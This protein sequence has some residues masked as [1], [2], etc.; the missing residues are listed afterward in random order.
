[1][2]NRKHTYKNRIPKKWGKGKRNRTNELLKRNKK[3]TQA[4]DKL[5]QKGFLK[6]LTKKKRPNI[7]PNRSTTW[8]L[9]TIVFLSSLL[10]IIIIIPTLIVAPFA[11][12]H[13][14]II[15]SDELLYDEEIKGN[16]A[17]EPSLSVAVMRT[18]S[19]EVEE[20]PLEVYVSRVVASEM[21]AEFEMEAL[22]AQALA[23]RTYIVNHLIHQED[24]ETSNVSDATDHQVYKNE[25]ELRELYGNDYTWKMDKLTEAVKATEGEI[26]TYNS[27]PIT[28]AFF[29]TSNGYTENSEDYWENEQPYLRSVESPWDK[30]SPRFL[31]QE[32]FTIDNVA[33]ALNVQLPSD[34]AL[35]IEI[36]RTDSERVRK[37]KIND[38]EFTGRDIREKLNLKSSDF[39]IKQKNNHL[40]FTTKGFGHGIGMSQYGANGLAKEGK[41]YEEIVKYYYQDVELSPIGE[42]APT[43]VV[44]K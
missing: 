2:K 37:L 19:G 14:E 22:K 43:L 3:S 5:H 44:Q 27:K 13:K 35:R 17:K 1:M 7:L 36:D 8:R 4:M 25:E 30:T 33:T 12:D 18:N 6:P 24:L 10:I 32:T 31:D 28:A 41:N 39:E 42:T 21:P 34:Q 15:T 16:D 9:P 23:T 38:Y 40:I 29:S 26:L 20:V 11:M